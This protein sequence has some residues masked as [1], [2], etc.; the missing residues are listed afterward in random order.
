MGVQEVKTAE[1]CG[2]KSGPRRIEWPRVRE[3]GQPRKGKS[4][5]S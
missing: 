3:C 4:G 2:V 5:L 1:D